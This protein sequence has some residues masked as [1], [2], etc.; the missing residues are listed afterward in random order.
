MALGLRVREVEERLAGK[1]AVAH[2]RDRPLHPRLV[3]R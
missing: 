1:E 2:E 3:L